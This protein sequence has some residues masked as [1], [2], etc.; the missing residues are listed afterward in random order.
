MGCVYAT[1][2]GK[3]VGTAA[4]AAR[5]AAGLSAS[6]LA[7]KAG[8][9]TST[10]TRIEKGA[11]DPTFGMLARLLDAAGHQLIA[12]TRARDDAPISLASLAN[13]ATSDKRP[14][15]DRLDPTAGVR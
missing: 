1:P 12:S 8:V 13:A 6:A 2:Y 15:P 14:A 5:R 7:A 3:A 11:T 4:C 10:V 9:P